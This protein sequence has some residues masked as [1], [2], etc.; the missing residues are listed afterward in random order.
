MFI[1]LSIWNNSAKHYFPY[2][3]E[4][5]NEELGSGGDKLDLP[6]DLDRV[7]ARKSFISVVLS[8]S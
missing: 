5:W 7:S 8:V 1:D 2:M 4:L 3:K 6:E